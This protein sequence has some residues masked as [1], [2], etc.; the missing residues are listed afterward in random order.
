MNMEVS[1]Q[2]GPGYLIIRARGDWLVDDAKRQMEA[3]REEADKRGLTRLFLDMRELS[4]PKNE[5]VRFETGKQL[6]RIWGHPFKVAALARPE[7]I[8]GFGETAAVNRG[9]HFAVFS[10]EKAALD[11]LRRGMSMEEKQQEGT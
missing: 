3:A 10:D 4:P 9:A 11:W 1:Y 8:T 6:A 7:N 5:L 2:E